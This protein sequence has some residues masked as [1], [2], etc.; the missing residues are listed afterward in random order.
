MVWFLANVIAWTVEF[1]VFGI[2][3]SLLV[4]VVAPGE[5]KTLHKIYK[6]IFELDMDEEES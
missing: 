2:A 6:T 4:E 5:C 3:L 1:M